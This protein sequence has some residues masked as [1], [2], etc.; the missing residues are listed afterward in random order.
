[1]S[2]T[3]VLYQTIGVIFFVLAFI[4][5][6]NPNKVNI[7]ANKW[8]AVFFMTAGLMVMNS[9]LFT[10][11]LQR[12]YQR[13]IGF[14]EMTRFTMAPALY[15]AILCL[16]KPGSLLDKKQYLHFIP[17]AIFCIYLAPTLLFNGTYNHL[18]HLLGRVLETFF[19]LVARF[20][21][22]VYWLLSIRMLNRHTRNIQLITSDTGPVDLRWLKGLLIAIGCMVVLVTLLIF[23]NLGAS[24]TVYVAGIFLAGSL[25][26]L[27][28]L[29]AQREVYAYEPEVIAEINEVILKASTPVESVPPKIDQTQ[30]EELKLRLERLMKEDKPYLDSELSL[31][32]LARELGVPI[33]VLS[34]LLNNEYHLNFFQ[35]INGYRVSEVKR[36][37]LSGRHKQL[38]I[39]G[40]AFN[41]G[42]N[43]KTTFNTA[44]K[45]D[46]GLSPTEFIRKFSD[47]ELSPELL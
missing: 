37:L 36:A 41:S 43:S 42:F 12:D 14:S 11:N 22:L 25:V 10:L 47:K 38:N 19:V 13:L 15:L 44:F 45:K 35:F 20:Q 16:T 31:P 23:Y 34:W 9:I 18:P 39:L 32:H 3:T 46:T 40:I 2:F 29:L 28:Y 17:S 4:S 27:Y 1:M 5:L 8:F 24:S 26:M 33:H 7:T 30:L 21:L 6:S